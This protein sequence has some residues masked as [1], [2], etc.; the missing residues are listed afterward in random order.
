MRRTKWATVAV[1]AIALGAAGCGTSDAGTEAAGADVADAEVA[2]TPTSPRPKGT[3]LLTKEV[4]RTDLD[5]SAAD[6]GVPANAPEYG[7]MSEGTPADSPPQ[8]CGVAFKGFGTETTPVDVARYEAV[9]G[10]LGERDWQQPQK[11]YERKNMDDGVI[12]E[13]RTVLNQRGWTVV[14][15]YRTFQKDGVI[16]L[17]AFEDACLKQYND[18]AGPDG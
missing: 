3:G 10:E 13:A 17:S 16:T 1:A 15:E 12:N 11:R 4:V 18:N 5:T 9:V 2:A 6:A 14:A 8:S 7:R